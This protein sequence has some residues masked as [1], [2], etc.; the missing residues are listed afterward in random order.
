MNVFAIVF[1]SRE[2]SCLNKLIVSLLSSP[3]SPEAVEGS[4]CFL[5]VHMSLA[6]RD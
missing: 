2:C 3:A 6:K 5:P 4:Y 1:R